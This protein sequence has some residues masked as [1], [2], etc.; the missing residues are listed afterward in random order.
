MNETGPS[1]KGP[2]TSNIT[3]S[4]RSGVGGQR[5]WRRERGELNR[6]PDAELIRLA[7]AVASVDRAVDGFRG[8]AS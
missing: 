6:L 1:P 3:A 2:A 8:A 4:D 7:R 5:A